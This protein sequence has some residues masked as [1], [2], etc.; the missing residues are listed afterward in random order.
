MSKVETKDLRLYS[1]FL[2]HF[3]GALEGLFIATEHDITNAIGKRLLFDLDNEE[4]NKIF[5]IRHLKDLKVSTNTIEELLP[6]CI[7][8]SLCSYNPL[9]YLSITEEQDNDETISI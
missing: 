7:D 3:D 1:F 5:E 8:Y 6:H 9:D 2:S 4:V